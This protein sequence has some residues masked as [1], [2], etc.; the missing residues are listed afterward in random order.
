MQGNNQ[1][2]Q[3]NLWDRTWKDKR[4]NITLWQMPNAFLIIWAVLTFLSLLVSGRLADIFSWTGSAALI[5]WALLEIFKGVNYF[6]R[7]L[8]LLVLVF[9]IVSL[10]KSL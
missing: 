3:R 4:G 5:V 2:E 9:A 7:A 8:G 10:I 6:R 1:H